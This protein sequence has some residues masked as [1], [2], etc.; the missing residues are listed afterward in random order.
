[1]R[2][3]IATEGLASDAKVIDGWFPGTGAW[4][5]TIPVATPITAIAIAAL[6][7]G[8]M[9]RR[10]IS[11]TIATMVIPHPTAKTLASAAPTRTAIEQTANA[12]RQ[13]ANVAIKAMP[14]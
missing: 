1:M 8:P 3:V 5:T 11:M 2:P 10:R 12:A 14:E 6:P 7:H 9:P 13:P 4:L